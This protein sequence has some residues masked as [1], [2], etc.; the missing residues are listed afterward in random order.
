MPFD[1]LINFCKVIGSLSKNGLLLLPIVLN[2]SAIAQETSVPQTGNS[3]TPAG[4]KTE[5]TPPKSEEVKK[6]EKKSEKKVEKKPEKKKEVK[7]EEKHATTSSSPLE[8]KRPISTLVTEDLEIGTGKIAVK[9]RMIKVN[10]TGWLFDSK[11]N[12]YKGKKLDN[13]KDHAPY[14]FVLGNAIVI[15]GWDEG[16][17]NMKVGGRRRLII[18]PPMAYRDRGASNVIPPNATLLYEISLLDV[19]EK[20]PTNPQ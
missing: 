13:G 10:Y 18:P 1:R 8:E 9:G 11:A 4:V 17:V 14:S 12:G 5:A 2:S 3:T 19:E 16:I 20:A 7:T 6:A 15:K